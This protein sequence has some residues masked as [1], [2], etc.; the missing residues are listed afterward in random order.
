MTD[1]A[2]SGPESGPEADAR[3][4]RPSLLLGAAHLAAL[5]TLAF[6]QPM[7]DLLGNNPDFFVARGNSSG[8][9]ILY[10]LT[11]TFAVPLI[12]L[13]IEA[14]VRKFNPDAQWYLH[15]FLMG[16]FGAA[17]ALQLIKNHLDWPAGLL[18]AISIALSLAGVFLYARWHFPQAFMD[19]LSVAPIIVLIIFFGFSSTSRLVL[20]REQPDPV[21]VAIAK[22]APVVMVIFDEFPVGSLMTPDGGIDATRYPAFANLADHSTWYRNTSADGAYT[23]L[24][25]PAILS[26]QKPNHDDLPIASD[27]PHSLFTLLGKSYDLRVMEA[28]TRICPDTL[29][30]E[31]DN[32]AQDNSTSD[33]FSDLYVVSKYLLLPDSLTRGL[34]DVSNSFYGF[35]ESDQV[36]TN[37]ESEVTGLDSGPT[38]ATG[39]T[40]ATGPTGTTGT[41]GDTSPERTGQGAARKLGRLF[42]LESSADEFE[43]VGQFDAK[44][45][46][47]QKKT[48]DLIHIEKP[49]YPWRHIPNGQR[50]SNLTAEWSGLLPNDGPWMAPPEI[51]NI[52][53]QRHL[54]EVGYTDTLLAQIINRL[55]QTGLWDKALFV[56]TADHGA[57]FQSKVPRRAAVT[58]NLGEIASIPLFIKSP[59]QTEP[60]VDEQRTC[61]TDILPIMAEDLGID[62]PWKKADCDPDK[63]TVVNSPNGEGTGTPQ[64]M[65]KQRQKELV[66]RIQSV[67]GTGHGWG[68][69]YR[70]GPHK[71]LIGKKVKN[72]DVLPIKRWRALPDERNAVKNYDPTAPTLRGLLQRGVT[73]RIPE[74]SVLAVAVNGRIQ[75]VGWTFK[76]GTGRGPGYSILL[77]PESLKSGFNQVDIYQLKD[78]GKK[79]RL[80]YDGSGR[81]PA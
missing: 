31:E 36:D 19:V 81:L 66:N 35:T 57:A 14:I 37:A 20:P 32:T 16:L 10:A 3:F 75:A 63:I 77:P 28:A 48:L 23:P 69:Y 22:P 78:D 25:V 46:P 17:F 70:F 79:L 1:V 60:K 6:V 29:C 68:P 55:K 26:G 62:Y 59:G 15:L 5:W 50:Y 74:K 52:A 53:L 24:A 73:D 44:L 58:E 27:Y 72:L 51:V 64:Q 39:I 33:L 45:Q 34:P 30:P 11:L 40:G 8:Q 7:L 71:E 38:G 54:L 65:L 80:V 67:F 12:C 13:A 43:R 76:D 4:Q 56:V 2:E 21:D 9:I 61:A 49:H 18:I 42:A 47:G 41:T